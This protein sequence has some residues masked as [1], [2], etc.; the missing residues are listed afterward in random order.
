MGP[1][2][3]ECSSGDETERTVPLK[4]ANKSFFFLGFLFFSTTELAVGTGFHRS[5]EKNRPVAHE[6]E[7]PQKKRKKELPFGPIVLGRIVCP[8]AQPAGRPGGN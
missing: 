7:G 8:Q 2:P 5:S 3:G 4:E 6:P 1:G